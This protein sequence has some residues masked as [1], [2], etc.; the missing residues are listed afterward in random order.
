M[1][2]KRKEWNAM[3]TKIEDL[4]RELQGMRLAVHMHIST[5]EVYVS[6]IV[7]LLLAHLKLEARHGYA[8]LFPIESQSDRGTEHG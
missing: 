2:V 3:C 5:G 1:K 4:E 8:W 6:A 7:P